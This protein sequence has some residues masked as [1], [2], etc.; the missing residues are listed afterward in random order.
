MSGK[1]LSLRGIEKEP[2][3]SR[4]CTCRTCQAGKRRRCGW[5]WYIRYMGNGKNRRERV[6]LPEYDDFGTDTMLVRAREL[7]KER[8][9][10]VRLCRL[11]HERWLSPRTCDEIRAWL[12]T[13]GHIDG[14][15]L[16]SVHRRWR[17]SGEDVGRRIKALAERAGLGDGY[18]G[19]SA[20]VG[21][22]C[23]LAAAGVDLAAV[24][25]AGRWQSAS[26]VARYS[27]R[28]AAGQGAVAQWYGRRTS[29]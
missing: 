24:M 26:M 21:M 22:A 4:D 13:A 11:K 25:Q 20:R 19:H 8:R 1:R 27:E 18:S 16:R 28:V 12:D 14:A 3:K 29:G 7:L 9:E 15:L 17:M 6:G 2:L 10:E 5:T 23:D